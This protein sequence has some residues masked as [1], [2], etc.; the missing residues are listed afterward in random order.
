M[1]FGFIRNFKEP[2][3]LNR[4]LYVNMGDRVVCYSWMPLYTPKLVSKRSTPSEVFHSQTIHNIK[5]NT[6]LAQQTVQNI[7]SVLHFHV[8]WLYH[9]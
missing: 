1:I 3:L 2:L 6:E 4:Q 8:I 9:T 7:T 5:Y